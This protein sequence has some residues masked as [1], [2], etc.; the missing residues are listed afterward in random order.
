M[1]KNKISKIIYLILA[2]II[3]TFLFISENGV[4]KYFNL[5]SEIK[6]LGEKIDSSK[7]QSERLGK[8]IDS[9]RNS[10]IKIEQVAR[11]K[12]RMKFEDEIPVRI[13][14]K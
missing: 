13:N 1:T 7:V 10:D 8:E 9:L 3:I 11:D 2:L 12:Y 5:K 14:K 4:I 6:E